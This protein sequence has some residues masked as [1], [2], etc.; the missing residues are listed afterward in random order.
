MFSKEASKKLRES[1]WIAFGKSFPR[2]WILYKTK[3]KGLHFKFHFTTKDAMVS[4][5]INPSS[6]EERIVLWEKV[7]A[8]KAIISADYLPEASFQDTCILA[9][10]KEI[11][12]V[13]IR[14]EGVSIHNKDSWQKAMVFLH[15][16]MLDFERFYEDYDDYL[17]P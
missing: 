10:G 14:K 4:L 15:K 9:N 6:L 5:D 13:F 8:V 3:V 7:T 16:T 1:F 17:K 2:K 12:R 11:S